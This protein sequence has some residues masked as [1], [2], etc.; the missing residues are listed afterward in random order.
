M[1]LAYDWFQN[2]IS[3]V[4][5]VYGLTFVIM[6]VMIW[7]T[8]KTDTEFQLGKVLW[9]FVAYALLHAPGDFLDMWAANN[10]ISDTLYLSGQFLTYS[11]YLFLFEFGRRLINISK[12]SIPWW[13]LPILVV[14]VVSLATASDSP[15]TTANVLFG[16]IIRFPAGIMS[17]LGFFWFY[18]AHEEILRSL[19]VKRYFVAAT[20][21]LFAWAFFCG[22]VRS[23]ADFFPANWLNTE[24][25]GQ[26]FRMPVYFFRSLSAVTLAWAIPGILGIFNWK[27]LN[28]LKKARMWLERQTAELEVKNSQLHDLNADKD[29][30]FSIIA[31]DLRGPLSAMIIYTK[32]LTERVD[33]YSKNNLKESLEK[34]NLSAV[35]VN[36]LLENLL[37]WSKIKQG[38]IEFS[39]KK[40]NVIGIVE[41]IFDLYASNAE[42]KGIALTYDMVSYTYIYADHPMITSVLRNLVSNSL[43]FTDFGGTIKVSV[44]QSPST[45][46]VEISVA[47]T[48]VG[49][50]TEDLANLF[51]I[52]VQFSGVGTAGEQGTGLGLK[53]CKD[54]VEIHRGKLQVESQVGKGTIFKLVLPAATL[55]TIPGIETTAHA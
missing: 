8:P 7:V 20:L 32:Q 39:P 33:T 27:V 38:M 47:D 34:L 17:G 14:S 5:F 52:D 19:K 23:K 49:M 18:K 36:A 45:Q 42:E 16:Y 4:Y 54:L 2:N 37:T 51:R 29:K 21:S 30:F 48:G 55:E 50:T 43:K 40:I 12:M 28:E 22:L 3:L 15:G 25:F 6:G 24:S 9:L 35:Q 46:F 53:I 13:V 1:D 31:H 41:G 10:R 11:S 44:A 26:T